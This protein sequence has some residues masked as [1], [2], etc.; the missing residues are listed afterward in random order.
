MIVKPAKEDDFTRGGCVLP[1]VD[2][3]VNQKSYTVT[4]VTVTVIITVTVT[5]PVTVTV[6]VAVT[7]TI[8]FTVTITV[9]VT[10]T[11]VSYLKWVEESARSL[12]QSRQPLE[13]VM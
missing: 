12:T 4:V 2:G 7:V 13:H 1:K 11:V 9:T 10:V 5:V 3:G 8:T 6:T